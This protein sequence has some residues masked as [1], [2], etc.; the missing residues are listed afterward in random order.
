[1]K[2]VF[3]IFFYTL[4]CVSSFA[5]KSDK[6][7][8]LIYVD[9]SS[10]NAQDGFPMSMV[11]ALKAEVEKLQDTSI[12]FLVYISDQ[13]YYK[14]VSDVSQLKKVMDKVY[15]GN[16]MFPSD[17]IAELR[18]LKDELENRTAEIAGAKVTVKFYSSEKLVKQ[19]TSS[20]PY[21]FKFLPQQLAAMSGSSSATNVMMFYPTANGLVNPTETSNVLRFYEPVN[22][23]GLNYLVES[24]K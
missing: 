22:G 2:T 7:F 13:Q 4:L 9:N 16:T 21:L 18:H 12:H 3:V 19:V 15:S 23:S 24:F 1:M 17:Q 8:H 14:T 11:D 10:S 5:Q 6:Q 20:L